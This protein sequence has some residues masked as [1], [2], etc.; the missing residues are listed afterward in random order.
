[1]FTNCFPNTLDTAVSL[2]EMEDEPDAFVITGDIPAMWIRDSCAQ[3]WPYL[4]FVSKDTAIDRL[5][6]GVIKRQTRCLLLDPYAN[7]F[8]SDGR[9]SPWSSDITAMKPGLHERKWE[10]DSIGYFMRLSY[11]YWRESNN[12]R[13]FDDRWLAALERCCRT[14]KE[15][16]SFDSQSSYRFQRVSSI[17]TETLPLGGRGNPFR[18]CGLVASGFRPSDDACIFPLLIPSNF[19]AALGLKQM[20]EL[21]NALGNSSV[22]QECQMAADGI[23]RAI[24]EHGVG[25]HPSGK[26]IF[27]YEVDGYGSRLI[28]DDANIPSL[29]SLPYLGCVDADDPIYRNTRA[30]IWSDANPYFFRG[31]SGSGIGSPHTGWGYVWPMSIIMFA[32]TSDSESEILNCLRALLDN[33]SFAGLMHESHHKDDHMDFTRPWFAWANSLFGELISRI[34]KLRPDILRAI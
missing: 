23:S 16:M 29:L 15:Q 14:L 34:Y 28:M 30:I 11:Y 8:Y 9:D 21:N 5:F 6:Q 4:P 10:L 3:I 7:A 19:L 17:S 32:L 12:C 20:A 31:A 25:M 13:P 33:H 18:S 26:P 1:L 2:T 27:F 22:A 24:A